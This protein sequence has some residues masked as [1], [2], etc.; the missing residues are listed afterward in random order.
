M[1]SE[2]HVET[3]TIQGVSMSTT[4]PE[5]YRALAAS[6]RDLGEAQPNV[7]A[8]FSQ[9]HKG[10]TADATLTSLTKEL[11]AL[12]IGVSTQCTGCIAFHVHDAIRAGATR[13]HIAETVGV[14]VLMGGGPAVVYGVEAMT[15]FDEFAAET[16]NN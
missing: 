14:A 2:F 12:A 16:A 3:Q 9:M 13:D 15:A 4:F 5:R 11:M 10:A 7:M 6:M 1:K 8:G